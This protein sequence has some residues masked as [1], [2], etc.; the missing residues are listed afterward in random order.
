M[1][2]NLYISKALNSDQIL[3]TTAKM[4]INYLTTN[5]KY[6]VYTYEKLAC[7]AYLLCSKKELKNPKNIINIIHSI[8]R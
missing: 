5:F 1:A 3:N 2:S 6:I 7:V 8:I 4:I